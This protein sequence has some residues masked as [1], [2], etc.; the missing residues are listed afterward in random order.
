MLQIEG[1]GSL[2]VTKCLLKYEQGFLVYV[3]NYWR[4]N[5]IGVLLGHIA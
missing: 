5:I 2:Q 1:R 4:Y 3:F